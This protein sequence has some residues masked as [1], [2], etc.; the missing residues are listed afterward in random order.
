MQVKKRIPPNRL[1]AADIAAH[2]GM[3]EARL[4][5]FAANIEACFKP[6]IKRMKRNH[7]REFDRPYR[8]HRQWLRK[9]HRFLLNDYRPHKAVH[10]GNKGRS[11]V[12]AAQLHKGGKAFIIG[13][14]ISKCYPSI[15]RAQLIPELIRYGFEPETAK[16]MGMLMTP[17][18]RISQGSPISADAL[19]YYLSSM[20]QSLFAI[21]RKL[22]CRYTRTYDDLVVSGF[23]IALAEGIGCLLDRK[24]KELGLRVNAEKRKE[25]G[26]QT[27]RQEQRVHNLVVNSALGVAVPDEHAKKALIEA[28][29]YVMGAVS[30]RPDSIVGL[31]H[32]R[33]RAMGHLNYFRQVNFAPVKRVRD[34]INQGDQIVRASLLRECVTRSK[35]WWKRGWHDAKILML[36]SRWTGIR[37][38]SEPMGA[39]PRDS[40]GTGCAA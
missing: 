38:N 20:D 2:L 5:G 3:S 21:C 32:R 25:R 28:E 22:G 17:R 40:F 16:L 33:E 19:N 7:V 18:N 12:T 29:G 6:P 15:S 14:D 11:C 24:I 13:R 37:S 27:N 35:K 39:P 23:N 34:L 31:V 10:G 4:W 30:A 1:T 9:L 8:T 36:A 26:F